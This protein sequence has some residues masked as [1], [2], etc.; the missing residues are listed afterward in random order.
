MNRGGKEGRKGRLYSPLRS[1]TAS[2]SRQ[3]LK[4]DCFS[5]IVWVCGE[6]EAAILPP[7]APLSLRRDQSSEGGGWHYKK[8]RDTRGPALHL[9]NEGC[10]IHVFTSL[11]PNLYTPV[12]GNSSVT[13]VSILLFEHVW[14]NF[15]LHMLPFTS[16]QLYC[17]GGSLFRLGRGVRFRA[18]PGHDPE[19]KGSLA[20]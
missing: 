9:A 16:P 3:L 4:P 20:H 17:K 18:G 10:H 2:D 6:V 1:R 14:N 11:L 19:L 12:T 13:K 15:S 8:P 7:Y 5:A